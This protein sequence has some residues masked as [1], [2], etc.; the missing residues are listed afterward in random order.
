RQR[1]PEP[2]RY[3]A[4]CEAVTLGQGMDPVLSMPELDWIAVVGPG[5]LGFALS[6]ALRT[7]GLAAA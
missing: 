3:T 5:R 2:G 6:E 7:T 1:N 4:G